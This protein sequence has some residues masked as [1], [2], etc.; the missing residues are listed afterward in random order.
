MKC[1]SCKKKLGWFEGTKKCMECKIK[2]ESS[3][4][5]EIR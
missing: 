1:R 4:A 2:K 3:S 5:L